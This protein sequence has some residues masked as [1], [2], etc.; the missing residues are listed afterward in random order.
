MG[1]FD[2]KKIPKGF[3]F[4]FTVKEI[5]AIERFTGIAFSKVENGNLTNSQKFDSGGFFQSS[6]RGFKIQ[7]NKTETIWQFNFHQTGFREE[8]LPQEHEKEIKLLLIE[9]INEYLNQIYHSKETDLYN[10]PQLDAYIRI[11]ENKASVSWNEV[12]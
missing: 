12:K 2:L 5:K 6:F 3:R 11:H 8:L 10:K 9:K 4:L 1:K 7:G